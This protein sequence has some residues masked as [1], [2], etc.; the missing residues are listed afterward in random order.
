MHK[1]STYQPYRLEL[2]LH[3]Y[4]YPEKLGLN[5]HSYSFWNKKAISE[6]KNMHSMSYTISSY[7]FC[8]L[9]RDAKPCDA[10]MLHV[11]A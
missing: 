9:I 7:L 10:D 8:N 3:R 5:I 2:P 6:E 4:Q 1:P 11:E